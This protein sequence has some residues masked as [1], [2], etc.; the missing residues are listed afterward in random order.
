MQNWVNVKIEACSLLNGLKEHQRTMI[1][2]FVFSLA[3]WSDHNLHYKFWQHK[4][5]NAL[6]VAICTELGHMTSS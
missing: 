1:F 5:R 4:L 3:A 2:W 6:G